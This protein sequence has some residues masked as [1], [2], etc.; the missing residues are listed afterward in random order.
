MGR[1]DEL[2]GCDTD[3]RELELTIS[4]DVASTYHIVVRL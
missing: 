3:M 2:A 4:S 1:G